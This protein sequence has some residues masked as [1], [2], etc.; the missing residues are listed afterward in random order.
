MII[1]SGMENK[2]AREFFQ[3]TRKE[4]LEGICTRRVFRGDVM[5]QRL[6]LKEL[7]LVAE[8]MPRLNVVNKKEM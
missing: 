8:R 4:G 6:V 3:G 5:M 1:E 2:E 7:E